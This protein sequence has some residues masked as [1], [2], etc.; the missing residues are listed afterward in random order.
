MRIV[1]DSSIRIAKGWQTILRVENSDGSIEGVVIRHGAKT[2][3]VISSEME[4]IENALSRET[5]LDR[6]EIVTPELSQEFEE[7]LI[8]WLSLTGKAE[9]RHIRWIN[10]VMLGFATKEEVKTYDLENEN[11]IVTGAPRKKRI[12]LG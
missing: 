1:H 6:R 2:S 7:A 8:E 3:K 10:D 5:I 9:Y 4:A 11:D 12:M